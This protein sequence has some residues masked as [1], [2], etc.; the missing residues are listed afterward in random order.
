MGAQFLDVLP[1]EKRDGVVQQICNVL[2]DVVTRGE[3]DPA[4]PRV[5]HPGIGLPSV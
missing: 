2:Q 5:A 1:E 4:F 3:D